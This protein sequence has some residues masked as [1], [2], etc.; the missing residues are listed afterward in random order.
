MEVGKFCLSALGP[1]VVGHF[2]PRHPFPDPSCRLSSVADSTPHPTIQ[3]L[4]FYVSANTDEVEE[5]AER[6]LK[7]ERDLAGGKRVRGPHM[8]FLSSLTG[9]GTDSLGT[10]HR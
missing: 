1:R 6:T 8:V 4:P 2:E 5:E 7:A 10:Q 9:A 3:V